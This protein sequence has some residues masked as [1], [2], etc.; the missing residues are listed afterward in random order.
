MTQT[1]KA[2]PS[3]VPRRPIV[4]LPLIPLLI[5]LA[6]L[7]LPSR[8]LA[9]Q[10]TLID[11]T[12]TVWRFNDHGDNLGTPWRAVNYPAEANPPWTNGIGLFGVDTTVRV[13]PLYPAP[14]QTPLVLGAGRITYYFRTRFII[15]QDPASNI[16]H[17]TAYIDDGA[18]FYVNGIEV[19]R[20]RLPT[21]PVLYNTT[22]QLANPEGV[23][24][25][26]DIDP[27][28]LVLGTNTI[29]VEVHQQN[30]SSSDVV[31]GLQMVATG[32]LAPT[33]LDPT[34]PADRTVNQGQPTTF[35]VV[36][37]GI[38]APD[39]RWYFSNSNVSNLLIPGANGSTY[40]IAAVGPEH[41]GNY[42]AVLSNSLG[43][44]TSRV[45]VLTNI[46]DTTAP[47][48]LYALGDPNQETILLPFSEPPE[49]TSATDAFNWAV[50]TTDGSG[51]LCSDRGICVNSAFLDNGT[52]LYL[53]TEMRDPSRSYIVRVAS[54]IPDP[55]GNQLPEGTLIPLATFP[56]NLISS[57]NSWRYEHSGTDLGT[58]WVTAAFSDA[59]WSNG[60][61]PLDVFRATA[62]TS[63]PHCRNDGMLPGTGELV[64]TCLLS[65]S[66]AANTA[67]YST[68]YFRTRFNFSGDAA[69]SVLSLTAVIDDAAVFYLNGTELARVGMPDGPL[70]YATL[71]NRTVGN[72]G[73]EFLT[74][75][76]RGLVQGEN[77]LA[78]EVHQDSLFSAD[79]TFG[80][81]VGAIVPS[82]VAAPQL[83]SSLAGG[84]ITI[85]WEPAVG[86][87][88]S[89]TEVGGPWSDVTPS[90]PPYTEPATGARKFFRVAVP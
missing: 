59:A 26:F 82:L 36:G 24:F 22:A 30:E 33:I 43:T 86:Q 61:A 84:N 28:N 55:F 69:H 44:A 80:L 65:L 50:D 79:L 10:I 77:V 14:F 5:V 58:N 88:Q 46:L 29:A 51:S 6:G 41:A 39:Y 83:S 12:N 13:P 35:F 21:D 68:A 19:N 9:D 89:A 37:S 3:H 87:L 38:P 76:P 73:P 85:S 81:S 27:T 52:N 49:P 23:P 1:V 42:Y 64:G 7:G 90:Q 45:A 70:T 71:A 66:N 20:I 47:Y 72:A 4:R 54:A 53:Q 63:E 74:L 75:A 2:F 48:V 62:E 32:T 25:D 56:V 67:Q 31:F 60:P 16:V 78:V 18:V 40:T 17:V 34:Q 15:A 8:T 57:T 11:I